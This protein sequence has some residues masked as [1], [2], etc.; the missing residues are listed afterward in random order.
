MDGLV[1]IAEFCAI[2]VHFPPN[3]PHTQHPLPLAINVQREGTPCGS[4]Q[5]GGLPVRGGW[6]MINRLDTD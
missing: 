4:G 2:G 3:L 5:N 1:L 6:T